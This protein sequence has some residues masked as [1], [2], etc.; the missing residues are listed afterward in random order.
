MMA[1]DGRTYPLR[2]AQPLDIAVGDGFLR[3]LLVRRGH[4]HWVEFDFPALAAVPLAHRNV[5]LKMSRRE[6]A[7]RMA[8]EGP[9]IVFQIPVGC[10]QDRMA[11]LV[12]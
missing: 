8:A 1:P 10:L 4:E 9:G 5:L 11:R 6:G 2:D 12:D 3:A 7:V